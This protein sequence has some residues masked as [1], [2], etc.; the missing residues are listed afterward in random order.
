MTATEYQNILTPVMI[1]KFGDLE[2]VSEWRS[3]RGINYQYS[4]RVDIAVGPFSV[5]P[6]R[7]RTAEYNEIITR[8]V[9][10]NFLR[11]IYDTHIENIGEEWLNEI[12]IPEF[13]FLI[14]KNQNARCLMSIEIENS[15]TKKHIMGSMINAA[16]LG[17]VGIGIAY[18]DSVLRTFIRMLNYM[19]FLKRVEKN[20]YDTT[21][22]LIVTK[23]QFRDIV[24]A[25]V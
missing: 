2:V 6:G 21:N 18:N 12:N 1:E 7:N 16:S 20:A 22:F 17:R 13:D 14:R 3:F 11:S 25:N 4:P 9:I 5:A 15:S 19:G 24:N 8:P 23:E 10:N